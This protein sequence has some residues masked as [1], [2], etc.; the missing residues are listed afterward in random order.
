ARRARPAAPAL[1]L[2][3]PPGV[4]GARRGA[5]RGPAP[6]GPAADGPHDPALYALAPL[7]RVTADALDAAL[8]GSDFA[9][10]LDR[11][12]ALDLAHRGAHPSRHD[13]V[14]RAGLHL[15]HEALADHLRLRFRGA[16]SP[17]PGRED[18]DDGEPA[19]S[20]PP[21]V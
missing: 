4:C 5:A 10:L 16:V 3:N 6:T 1:P 17:G 21:P 9:E 7:V 8:L 2:N 13:A 12:R 14:L 18:P 19:R 11:A 20:D 15:T